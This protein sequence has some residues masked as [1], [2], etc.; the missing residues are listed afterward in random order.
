MNAFAFCYELTVQISA[1]AAPFGISSSVVVF[2]VLTSISIMLS[3]SSTDNQDVK[4][5]HCAEQNNGTLKQWTGISPY[6]PN[7]FI[8]ILMLVGIMAMVAFIINRDCL[9]TEQEL[10][11]RH[12]VHI[13]LSL[14]G[15]TA[16]YLGVCMLCIDYLLIRVPC[17]HMWNY[18]GTE[19]LLENVIHVIFSIVLVIFASFEAILCWIMHRLNFQPSQWVWHG[20][21]VVQAANAAVWFQSVVGES[22]LRINENADTFRAHFSFCNTTNAT[23]AWCTESSI[24]ARWFEWSIPLFFP[25]IIEFSLLVSEL[26]L[27]KSISAECRTERE[28]MNQ[29][30]PFSRD[31]IPNST[32]S[33]RSKIFIMASTVINSV[34]LVLTILVRIGYT[35]NESLHNQLQL[36]ENVFTLYAIAY[37]LYSI[38]CCAVGIHFCRRFRRPHP[39]TSY[40]E[41]L[42]L[43]ATSGVLLNSV[44]RIV[45]FAFYCT[46]AERIPTAVTYYAVEFL[47]MFQALVQV[48][49]Y[50]C[51]KDVMFELTTDQPNYWRFVVFKNITVVLFIINFVMWITDSFL[52][53]EMSTSIT[54]CGFSIEQWPVFDNIV[55]PITIFYRFNS[56][57]LFWTLYRTESM[58]RPSNEYRSLSSMI[59]SIF[60]SIIG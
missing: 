37:T 7:I 8:T 33:S 52:L 23:D 60:R 56:A 22:Y 49:F 45:A 13:N 5:Q 55:I 12:R 6:I 59:F 47:A 46:T 3:L 44:K 21:A 25:S 14:R 38:S 16:F 34:Y 2:V 40:I 17:V 43:F 31:E 35:S 30:G 29:N 57:L 4:N 50:F 9:T 26:F 53:P 51:A 10:T 48:I 18:C 54:P 39:H 42:L 36:Y 24:A 15:I 28:P 27:N 19:I 20:L 58:R 41:Y 32:R 11:G 1:M